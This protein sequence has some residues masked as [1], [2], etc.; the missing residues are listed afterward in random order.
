LCKPKGVQEERKVATHRGHLKL[1]TYFD[2][3]LEAHVQLS[4]LC[5]AEMLGSLQGEVHELLVVTIKQVFL[6]LLNFNEF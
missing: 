4:L 6:A 1:H 3:K 5:D 2:P